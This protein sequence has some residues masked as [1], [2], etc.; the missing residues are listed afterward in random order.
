MDEISFG[1]NAYSILKTARDE[2]GTFLPTAFKS[3]GDYKA[4][5]YA[6]L[7]VPT[8]AIFGLNEFAVRFPAALLGTL[9]I[10]LV[11]FLVLKIFRNEKIAL[12]S[13]ASL[14]I[15][16]WHLQFS[17]AGF[18][19]NTMVFFEILGFTLFLYS[20]NRLRYLILAAI[21]FG[22]AFNAYHAA[23]IWIPI[24][25]LTVA[26][27]YRESLLKQKS[28][29]LVAAFIL[30]IFILPSVINFKD[31]TTRGRDVLIIGQKDIEKTFVTNYLTHFSPVFLF[32]SG[33]S[34]GRHSVPGIGELYIFKIPFV[35]IGLMVLIKSKERN[36]RL[37]L[38]WFLIAPIPSAIATPAP[39]ALRDITSIP[40]WSIITALGIYSF[41]K[42]RINPYLKKTLYVIVSVIAFYNIITYL[43]LYHSHYPKE[44]AIDWSAGT[45]EM[46]QYVASVENN[47]GRIYVTKSYSIPYIYF[48]FYTKY[49]PKIYQQENGDNSHFGKYY[50]NT[51]DWPSYNGRYL[52]IDDGGSH[53]RNLLKEIYINNNNLIYRIGN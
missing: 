47:Y 21:A 6:Y 10:P 5:L 45:K 2:Y 44:K 18:E 33:D 8:I 13:S 51:T 35:F 31:V 24:F 43:H 52:V 49:D 41:T 4:P 36:C 3:F 14:A 28:K 9:T 17:R 16:P 50:F 20:K 7:L 1:Y 15:S 11:Y 27:Y 37:L 30:S 29:I 46:I 48:L 12:L 32:V 25:L 53:P 23:R 26:I 19:A 34:I 42:V 40:L 22:L 38:A 39:H